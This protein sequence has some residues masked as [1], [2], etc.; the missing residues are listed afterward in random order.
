MIILI[1]TTSTSVRNFDQNKHDIIKFTQIMLNMSAKFNEKSVLL[2]LSYE[3]H[4]IDNLFAATDLTIYDLILNLINVYTVYYPKDYTMGVYQLM[5]ANN[6][7]HLSFRKSFS[8]PEPITPD[9]VNEYV[10]DLHQCNHRFLKGH[11]T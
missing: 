5:I 3:A 8:K 9:E 10:I 6:A 1:K 2:K 7:F 4:V 11:K